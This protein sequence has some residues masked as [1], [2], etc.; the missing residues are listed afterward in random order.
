MTTG[1]TCAHI[2]LELGVYL[3]GAIE[4]AQ[5]AIV[6]RHLAACR[7]CRAELAGLAGLPSL[8]RRVPPDAVSQQVAD[9]DQPMRE[10]PLNAVLARV[11]ASRR[12]RKLRAV[13]ATVVTGLAAAF[14]VQAWHDAVARPP[15]AV[16][17]SLAVTAQAANPVTGIWAAVRYTARPW[18]T[19]LAVTVTGVAAGTRCQLLVAG[20]RGQVISAG[21]WDFVPGQSAWYAAS[22]PIQAASLRSF[23]ITADGRTLVTIP[24]R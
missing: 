12:R 16:A 13:A 6:D 22:V 2:R 11:T 20:Q 3:L 5:R 8:L 14:A 4:P 18:G 19:E 23:A 1:E 21:G 17:P 10:A 15:A 9:G 24:V 7:S